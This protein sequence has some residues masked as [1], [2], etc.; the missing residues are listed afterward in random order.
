LAVIGSVLS[1][2][3]ESVLEGLPLK[4]MEEPQACLK[5]LLGPG[6]LGRGLQKSLKEAQ[7]LC[8]D[9]NIC[10]V[11]SFRGRPNNWRQP[12]WLSIPWQLRGVNKKRFSPFQVVYY[13]ETPFHPNL[14]AVPEYLPA[15]HPDCP[16]V[17]PSPPTVHAIPDCHPA[18]HPSDCYH[19]QTPS[20]HLQVSQ[21]EESFQVGPGELAAALDCPRLQGL[22]QAGLLGLVVGH[23]E[24]LPPDPDLMPGV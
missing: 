12:K 21:S 10:F 7:P 6:M 23:L 19:H 14:L 20:S 24:V 9:L 18:G 1:R 13:S 4:E 15:D 11:L 5:Q 3:Q 22:D 2:L 17:Q 16:A 8:W